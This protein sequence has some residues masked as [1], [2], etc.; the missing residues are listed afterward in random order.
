[1]LGD[2]NAVLL[3]YH[4]NSDIPNLLGSMCLSV[5][6]PHIARPTHCTGR[7]ATLI[8]NIFTSNKNCPYFSSNLAITLSDHHVQF[9]MVGNQCNS[10]E[11]NKEDQLYHSF[12]EIEKTEL[13]NTEL[14]LECNNFNLSSELLINKVDRL[15][16][17]NKKNIRLAMDLQSYPQIHKN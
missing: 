2:F 15:K 1:M 4:T 17:K 12:Q 6:L 13:C 11:N 10:S 9:L 14:C 16:N 7:S 5:F 8:N 3:Q